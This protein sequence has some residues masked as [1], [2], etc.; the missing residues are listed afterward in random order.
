MTRQ[1]RVVMLAAGPPTTGGIPTYVGHLKQAAAKDESI[2]LL[3]INSSAPD[4]KQHPVRRILLSFQLAVSLLRSVR[5]GCDVVYLP[6]SGITS[7]YEKTF[8]VLICKAMRKRT[9]MHMHGGDLPALVQ[10]APRWKRAFIGWLLWLPDIYVVFSDGWAKFVRTI[11]RQEMIRVVPNGIPIQGGDLR[12]TRRD[13]GTHVLLLGSVGERKGHLVLLETILAINRFRE[14]IFFHLVGGEEYLGDFER[15]KATYDQ[16][17]ARNY[18]FY[19]HLTG[20]DKERQFETANI[21]TLPSFDEAFP[22]AILEAM[23][24]GLPIVASRVG[25]IPEIIEEGVNGYLISPGDSKALTDAILTLANDQEMC[26]LLGRNNRKKVEEQYDLRHS[27]ARL[28][29]V[30]EEAVDL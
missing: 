24:R 30:F 9:I 25:A 1:L 6:H 23:Y 12:H 14:D 22:H 28:K 5:R 7:L 17:G 3:H 29:R 15:I 8:F 11:S 26:T 19:G 27:Y 21:F 2:S 10:G 13:A 16:S 4:R 18:R 20:E